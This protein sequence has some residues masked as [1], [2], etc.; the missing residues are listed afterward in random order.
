MTKPLSVHLE[1]THNIDFRVNIPND[2]DF[3]KQTD[4]IEFLVNECPYVFVN[5]KTLVDY[6]Y[7]IEGLDKIDFFFLPYTLNND[8]VNETIK[9]FE[10]KDR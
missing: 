6:N 9:K 8:I 4:F 2:W 3:D 5:K 10:D 1:V 7:S